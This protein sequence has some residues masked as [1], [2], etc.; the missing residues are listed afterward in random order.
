[1]SGRINRFQ[2][3]LKLSVAFGGHLVAVTMNRWNDHE[4][5]FEYPDLAADGT[6]RKAA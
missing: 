1:L 3:A 4:F 5:G 6:L 2:H